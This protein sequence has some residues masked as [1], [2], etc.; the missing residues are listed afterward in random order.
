MLEAHVTGFYE[1]NTVNR[2]SRVAPIAD[3]MDANDFKFSRSP[4]AI[5]SA[6]SSVTSKVQRSS[7]PRHSPECAEG[8]STLIPE[9]PSEAQHVGSP[10]Q[11]QTS[12]QT[13]GVAGGAGVNQFGTNVVLL[14]R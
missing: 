3:K 10:P 11:P 5:E 12:P 1:K 2:L 6:G 9:G 8:A 14:E 4:Y 13:E 7:P